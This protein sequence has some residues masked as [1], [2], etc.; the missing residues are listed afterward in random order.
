LYVTPRRALGGRP[1]VAH[2]LWVSQKAS[3][4]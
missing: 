3:P 2:I 4:R 1:Q